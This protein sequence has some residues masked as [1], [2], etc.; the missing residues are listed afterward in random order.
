MKRGGGIPHS[1]PGKFQKS[2]LTRDKRK[3]ILSDNP[4][5]IT[6][7]MPL[8]ELTWDYPTDRDRDRLL[9]ILAHCGLGL[10]HY[11][12]HKCM[13]A[14]LGCWALAGNDRQLSVTVIPIP[15]SDFFPCS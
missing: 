14:G 8:R 11:I 5:G 15:M 6:E 4:K 10:S 13:G 1:C 9:L 3:F 7:S 2:H 12:P